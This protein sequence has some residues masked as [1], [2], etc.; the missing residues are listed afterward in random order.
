MKEKQ[1]VLIA[2]ILFRRNYDDIL[3]R[4]VDEDQAHEMIRGF[5]EGIC[6]GHFSP[7]ATAHNII[8]VGFY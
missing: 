6:S 2:D 7:T 3:P 1:Y 5:H 8:R 4:C